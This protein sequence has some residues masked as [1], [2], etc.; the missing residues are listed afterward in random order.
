MRFALLEANHL[1]FDRGAIAWPPA[2][3]RA[4][5]DRRLAKI[6]FDDCVALWRRVGFPRFFL[7]FRARARGETE[8]KS[9]EV[10]S[11]MGN[12][13]KNNTALAFAEDICLRFGDVFEPVFEMPS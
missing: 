8:K 7:L 10:S 6:P 1:V 3:N 5:I 4:G 11:R 9:P 13:N 2:R 12:P